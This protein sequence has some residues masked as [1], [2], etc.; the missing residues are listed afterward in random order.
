MGGFDIKTEREKEN[1]Y[2]SKRTWL[3]LFFLYSYFALHENLFVSLIISHLDIHN[4]YKNK[5]WHK[6]LN[7]LV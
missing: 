3:S 5:I 1:G 2:S 7:E 6:N 4:S